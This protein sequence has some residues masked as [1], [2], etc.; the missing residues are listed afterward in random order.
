M[1]SFQQLSRNAAGLVWKE[2][3]VL[4]SIGG[5]IE[6]GI[7]CLLFW[8]YRSLTYYKL[9][10]RERALC[11]PDRL[12]IWIIDKNAKKDAK[13]QIP[14][15]SNFKISLI[16]HGNRAE[17]SPV[18]SVIIPVITKSDDRAAGVRFVYHENDYRSN[19]TPF[20]LIIN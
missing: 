13:A 18:R 4:A 5:T 9:V 11:C 20:S 7:M 3:E 6:V 8:L 17:W 2:G 12:Q 14:Q 19:W 1:S 16:Y 10:S 15:G